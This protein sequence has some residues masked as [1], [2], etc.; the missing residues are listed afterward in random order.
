VFFF[1]ALYLQIEAKFSGGK[2][3]LQFVAMAIAMVVAGQI[4]GAWTAARGPRAPMLVGCLLAGGGM[5]LVDGL[6]SP[7]V[8]LW[9]LSAALAVVGLGLG[10]ALVAVTASVLA[11]VPAERSGMAAS[12]VN[13]SRELGGVLAVAILGAVIN[14][15]L[16][17][18][19]TAHLGGL[20]VS[21][22]LQQ[23]VLHA[24]THGGL[25][26]NAALAIL[27]N[28]VVA[29]EALTNPGILGKILDAA[30]AA[31]GDALHVGLTVSAVILLVGAAVS[32][33]AARGFPKPE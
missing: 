27:A 1:T 17:S 23:L 15:R 2:I 25:P 6:L 31:F 32:L 26:A 5:F 10:L 9:K 4:A 21:H 22:D 8:N 29:A 14:G 7:H 16:V 13:T 28:P 24:V 33:F 19:L 18:D 11:I 30:E 20:G 3:A 12:T